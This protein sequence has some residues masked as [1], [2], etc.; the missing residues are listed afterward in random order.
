MD[1][2]IS[3]LMKITHCLVLGLKEDFFKPHIK[4]S[5][6]YLL[7]QSRRLGSCF[8]FKLESLRLSTGLTLTDAEEETASLSCLSIYLLC[9]AQWAA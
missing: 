2:L 7:C 5:V 4:L 9:W 1:L 3:C 6:L 8:K